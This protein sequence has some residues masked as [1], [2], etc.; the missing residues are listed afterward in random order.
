MQVRGHGQ[1]VNF[2]PASATFTTTGNAPGPERTAQVDV[3][4]G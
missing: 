2:F 3:A 1:C 4:A